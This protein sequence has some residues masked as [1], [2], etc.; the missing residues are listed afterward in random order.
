MIASAQ[1]TGAIE[2]EPA[3]GQ[4]AGASSVNPCLRRVPS[5]ISSPPR[6]SWKARLQ[7]DRPRLALG[8][9][10]RSKSSI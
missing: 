2:M 8:V 5:A 4:T 9:N 10:H 1:S 3:H 6:L 7:T